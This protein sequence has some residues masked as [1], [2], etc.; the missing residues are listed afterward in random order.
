MQEESNARTDQNRRCDVT[1]DA[2][3]TEAECKGLVAWTAVESVL[4]GPPVYQKSVSCR[5]WMG[6]SCSVIVRWS[7]VVACREGS[8]N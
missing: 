7:I 2:L 6:D 1:Q 3:E 4:I 5:S 8:P